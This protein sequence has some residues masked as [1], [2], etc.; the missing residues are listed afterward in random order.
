MVTEG[1]FRQDLRFRINTVEIHIPPLRERIEDIPLLCSHFLEIYK[2]KYH[3]PSISLPDYVI[4]KLMKY[5]WPGNIRELQ[6]A[7]E[8]AVIMSNNQALQ[9]SDFSFLDN[10]S[11]TEE[12]P[13]DTYNLEQLEKWAVENALKKHKGNITKA[14]QELGLTR[15]AMYRRIEKYE[16]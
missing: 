4:K 13:L 15:G 7:I 8:R 2:K 10:H 9:S 1:T 3:K 5:N 12:S 14:A 6:H 11:S 16:L